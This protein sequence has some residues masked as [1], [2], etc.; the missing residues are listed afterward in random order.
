M[1][2][3]G[4]QN[5]YKCRNSAHSSKEWRKMNMAALTL[6]VTNMKGGVGKTTFV[7][8]IAASIG[9]QGVQTR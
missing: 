4:E 7:V 9:V 8:N 1:F 2:L 3:P 5:Q 6:T